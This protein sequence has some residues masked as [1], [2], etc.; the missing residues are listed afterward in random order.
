MSSPLRK[1]SSRSRRRRGPLAVAVAASCAAA[2]LVMSPAAAVPTEPEPTTAEPSP[3]ATD[4][5]VDPTDEATEATESPTED[6]PT[7]EPT[8]PV[9][10]AA[11]ALVSPLAVPGFPEPTVHTQEAYPY[12]SAFTS[13]WTRADAR[14]L[15]AMSDPTAGSR[16][17]SMPAEFTM[18]DVPISF[19]ATNGDVW[20]WD[21][22][23]LTNETSHQLSFKGWEVAFSLVAD[24]NAGYTFDDRHTEA[25]LG[26]FFRP[27]GLSADERPTNGGWTYGGHV[28]PDGASGAIFEDQSFSHQTEWSG[29]TRLFEGNKLRVFYTAVAF[30]RNDD[31][32]NRKPYDPRLVQSEGRIFADEDGVWLTGFRD[33]HD[34]LKADGIWYQ[35]GEQN[36]FFNF[37]D[38]FTFEDPANPGETFMVFEGNTAV[39]RENQASTEEDLG[40]AEGDPEAE[41]LADV[42][43]SGA[44]YQMANVGLAIATN[45]ALTEWEF[46]PPILS[47]NCVTDQ[48]ETPDLHPGRSLLPVHHQ[49]P[50]HLRCGDRRTRGGL[51]L[52][53]ERHQI[54]L[55]AGQPRERAGSG[56]PDQPQLSGRPAV[57]AGLQPGSEHLPVLL[58]LRDAGWSRHLL[59]RRD[60]D[61]RGVRPWRLARA[62]GAAEHRRCV[63]HG[64]HHLW[65]RRAGRLRRHPGGSCPGR[66]GHP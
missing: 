33:Q 54:G 65:Q 44:T 20:V 7:T 12:D 6:Q 45:A 32:S 15:A 64:R 16:E 42:L 47:A 36:E 56:Q 24:R 37:R 43:G 13:R 18:P 26:Y 55:P 19:P 3:S 49:S 62:D 50:R 41:S 28:F 25:R 38:P 53:R 58:A 21:T 9:P 2:L 52:R 46:L 8:E 59:H 5:A 48:T 57:R 61:H 10:D 14:Q 23:T 39:P 22:W 60:R 63:D 29:S 31:G 11:D 35:N 4:P 1:P 27:A 34:L 30:Y 51:R 40:Y 17:N 66:P